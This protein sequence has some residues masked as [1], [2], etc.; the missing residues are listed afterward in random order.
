[1]VTYNNYLEECICAFGLA[2]IGDFLGSFP[3]RLR[4]LNVILGLC[5]GLLRRLVS[6]FIYA[7]LLLTVFSITKKIIKVVNDEY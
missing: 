1:V 6:Y 5:N 7:Q 3:G 2:L 4:R